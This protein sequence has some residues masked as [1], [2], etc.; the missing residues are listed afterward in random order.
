MSSVI[1]ISEARLKKLT[2][3]HDNVEPQE[4]TPFVVQAQDIYI[5]DILGTTFYQAL[6]TKITNNDVTGYYQT[7]LNDYIAPTLANYAVYLAFPSLNYKIKNKAILTPTSEESATTDLTALKYVR[8]SIQDTAQFYGERTREYIRDNQEQFPEYLNPG[9]DGMMP[10]KN[11]PYFHGIYI[12]KPYGCGDNLPD[13]PN[14]M[15]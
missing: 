7:L 5:Q 9:T 4:L 13:N 14:P 11:N 8:G 1:F 6:Q 2:A 10:N 12:P 15:N 3:V